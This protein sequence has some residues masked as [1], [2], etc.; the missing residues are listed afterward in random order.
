LSGHDFTRQPDE[1]AV[2]LCRL[3]NGL[4]R[5]SLDQVG[6]DFIVDAGLGRGHRDVRTMRL[7]TLPAPRP[8]A[9]IWK[10]ADLGENVG[11]RPAY[12][13]MLKDGDLDRC[14]V[15]LLAGK[16]VGAPFVGAIAGCLALSEVLRLLHGGPIHQLIDLDLQSI[17]H[18]SAIPHSY[19]FSR[20]NPGYVAAVV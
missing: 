19:D 11:E 12:N 10:A 17:E 6:F 13:K 9:A 20:L 5:H 14:G 7:H 1:P 15:T 3:D 8:A 2:A 18:R 16:A 4:G